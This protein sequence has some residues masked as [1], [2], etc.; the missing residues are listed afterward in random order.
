MKT[1]RKTAAAKQDERELK[2]AFDNLQ[3]A[4]YKIRSKAYSLNNQGRLLKYLAVV[5]TK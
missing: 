5:R 4:A 3:P 2:V 1:T